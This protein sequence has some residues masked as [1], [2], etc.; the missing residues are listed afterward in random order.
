MDISKIGAS[1]TWL[2]RIPSQNTNPTCPDAA[3][4]YY[5][6][7]DIADFSSHFY[8]N[9]ESAA[10]AIDDAWMQATGPKNISET[11]DPSRTFISREDFVALRQEMGPNAPMEWDFLK[12]DLLEVRKSIVGSSDQAVDTFDGLLDN[13]AARYA[14]A[15]RQL[16]SLYT[17]DAWKA[18]KEKLDNLFCETINQVAESK[19]AALDNA[20]QNYG[21]H[22][23]RENI[24]S[25]V[26]AAFQ[27]SVDTYHQTIQSHEDYAGI[28]GTENEWLISVGRFAA[29]ALQSYSQSLSSEVFVSP[30]AE[31]SLLRLAPSSAPVYAAKELDFLTAYITAMQQIQTNHPAPS[32]E[33]L[34]VVLG[35]LYAKLHF[36]EGKLGFGTKMKALTDQCMHGFYENTIESANRYIQD[37][38]RNSGTTTAINHA[39]E[40]FMDRKAVQNIYQT[41]VDAAKSGSSLEKIWRAGY[42]AGRLA[43]TERQAESTYSTTVRYGQGKLSDFFQYFYTKTL[44][45]GI[46]NFLG[47]SSTEKLAESW[48]SILKRTGLPPEGDSFLQNHPYLYTK[49]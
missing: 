11:Q 12:N 25:S 21:V 29:S 41:M 43:F 16:Q 23:E 19:A 20:L 22:G 18:S 35:D 37:H 9:T 6:R 8:W 10:H 28:K 7:E 47:E 36:A 17:G 1:A 13:L 2:Q 34:G 45:N 14:V 27:Q 3:K 46:A 39:N 4:G 40:A 24:K 48:R 49:A 32:E 38:I 44:Q 15:Y 33:E 5:S 26:L 42:E 31:P 30:K